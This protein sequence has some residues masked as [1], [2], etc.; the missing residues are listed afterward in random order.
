MSQPIVGP[1]IR[2]FILGLLCF[3]PVVSSGT[4]TLVLSEVHLVGTDQLTVRDVVRGLNLKLGEPTTRQTLVGACADFKKLRLFWSTHCRPTIHGRSVTL[5]INVEGE[6]MWV[7]FDNFVW[8]TRAELLARLKQEIPLFKPGLPGSSGLTS[9]IL[10]VLQQVLDERGIKGLARYDD[11]FW[12]NRGMNVFYVEGISTPVTA[13]QI[14]GENAPSSEELA[15][16]SQFYTKEEFSA[17]GLNW[18]VDWVKRDLYK[19]RGYLMP[20]AGEPIIQFLGEKDGAYPVLSLIH[21]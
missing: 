16:W 6:G 19:P 9:D 11:R 10:R 12:T 5:D 7:V 14:D 4:N 8:I 2:A 3:L 15:K 1:V 20:V 17:A 18:V 13:L 21:I